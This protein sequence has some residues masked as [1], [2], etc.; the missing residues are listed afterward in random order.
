[1]HTFDIIVLATIAIFVGIGIYRGLIEEAFHLAAMFGGF[2][3]AYILYPVMYERLTFLKSS[4][5]AKTVISFILCYI[6]IGFSI[7][8][9]G[10]M[11]KK[12]IH[13]TLLG[14]IDRLLGGTTGILKAGIIIWVFVLSVT[15]LPDSK[16]KKAFSSSKT[17]IFFKTLPLQL[18]TPKKHL[19]KS[20][21]KIKKATDTKKIKDVKK[22]LEKVKDGA[23]ALKK[24]TDKVDSDK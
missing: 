6:I 12:L 16:L 15:Y 2:V 5:N 1:M 10:W 23:D 21:K 19:S 17:C 4:S 22:H 8:I 9:I 14:W 13:M 18:K 7:L 20:L 3:G 24:L 11:L